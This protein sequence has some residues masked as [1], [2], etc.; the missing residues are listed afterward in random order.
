VT[1]NYPPKMRVKPKGDTKLPTEN[2]C[3][4]KG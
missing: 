4:T 1:Q 2:A 3:E